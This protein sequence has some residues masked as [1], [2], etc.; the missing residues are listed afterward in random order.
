MKS[1]TEF[2]VN[3]VL[4]SDRFYDNIQHYQY[5][6]FQLLDRHLYDQ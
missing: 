3:S 2:S 5:S 1:S 6:Y 4:E